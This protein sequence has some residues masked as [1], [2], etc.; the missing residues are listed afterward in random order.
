MYQWFTTLFE[1]DILYN[2]RNL[3][4]PPGSHIPKMGYCQSSETLSDDF[5]FLEESFFYINFVGE[6]I[7]ESLL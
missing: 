1:I 6:T 3:V 7:N 2:T 5:Y 4:I